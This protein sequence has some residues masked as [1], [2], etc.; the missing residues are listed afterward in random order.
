MT[1]A[2]K[3]NNLIE[4]GKVYHYRGRCWF[5]C[6]MTWTKLTK[7]EKQETKLVEGKA[8]GL[9]HYWLEVNGE[10]VDPHYKILDETLYVE[11]WYEY[12]KEKEY[13][14]Y[15]AKVDKGYENYEERP[16]FNWLNR[17]KWAKVYRL[18]FN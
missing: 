15:D 6:Y 10:V 17:E 12:V 5:T 13:N 18:E 2:E 3:I 9:D 1:T 11:D 4:S 8:D 7:K 14:L 16:A